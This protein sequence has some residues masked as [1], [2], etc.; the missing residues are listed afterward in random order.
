MDIGACL[1]RLGVNATWVA[2]E[3]IIVSWQSDEPQPTN[4]ELQDVWSLIQA[5]APMRELREKRDELLLASD[6]HALPDW[7][8]ERDGWLVYRQVL[9]DLPLTFADDPSAVVYPDPPQ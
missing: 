7:P 8:H 9:R 2:K 4:E 5:E 6:K 3:Q 1:V